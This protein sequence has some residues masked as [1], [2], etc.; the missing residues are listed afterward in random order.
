MFLLL[1][2]YIKIK[3]LNY[4]IFFGSVFFCSMKNN[5]AKR[6]PKVYDFLNSTTTAEQ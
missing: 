3:P 2:F 5:E 4:T 6:L 1:N